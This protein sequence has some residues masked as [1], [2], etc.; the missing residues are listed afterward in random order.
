MKKLA[1]L[2]MLWLPVA[3]GAQVLASAEVALQVMNLPIGAA[4]AGMAGAFSTVAYD[5]SALYWNPAGMAFQRSNQL[6]TTY[7]DWLMDTSYQDFSALFHA[8]GGVWGARFAYIGLGDFDL[9]DEFGSPAGTV[10]PKA[11]GANMGV[12]RRFGRLG[13][14]LSGKYYRENGAGSALSGFGFDAGFLARL[15][16]VAFAWGYRNVGSAAGISTPSNFYLGASWAVGR[17]P[18]RLRLATDG[19]SIKGRGFSLQHGLEAIVKDALC[20]R[21][22]YEWDTRKQVSREPS[23]FAGGVGLQ[24]KPFELD[25]SFT[26][27]GELG[28]AHKITMTYRFGGSRK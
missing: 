2:T 21:A 14:G 25:Y 24:L 7:N 26:P 16:K 13:A 12:A 3:A 28:N 1:L 8:G 17:S 22:G 27:F 6:Q 9:R 18:F 15:R 19:N 4:A 10:S 23:G 20:F 11:W 5:P